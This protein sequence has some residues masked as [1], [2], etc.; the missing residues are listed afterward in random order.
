MR[1]LSPLTSLGIGRASLEDKV[2]SEVHQAW[3]EYGPCEDTVRRILYDT[4]SVLTDMGV[5]FGIAE[6]LDVLPEFFSSGTLTDLQQ[7][8]GAVGFY[9]PGHC[10]SR[11]SST[12]LT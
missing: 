8:Q 6:S 3:L 2:Q 9:S 7:Y 12:L 1:R 4:R 10:K 5:E 11:A